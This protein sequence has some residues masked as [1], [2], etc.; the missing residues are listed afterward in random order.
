[1]G[2]IETREKIKQTSIGLFNQ[3]GAS[4]IS[5]MQIAKASNISTGNMYYYFKSKEEVI[6]SIWEEDLHGE[7]EAVFALPDFGK[8]ENGMIQGCYA[9]YDVMQKYYFFF[10]SSLSFCSMM[11][12]LRAFTAISASLR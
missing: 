12:S 3:Y 11:R 6:R 10:Q 9:F 5:K 7:L 8:S 4:N 2:S 1:M